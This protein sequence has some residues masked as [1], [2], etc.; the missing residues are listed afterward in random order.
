M[1]YEHKGY[2]L[3]P[4]IKPNIFFSSLS[5]KWPF[6]VDYNVLH[7][8]ESAIVVSFEAPYIFVFVFR[9]TIAFYLLIPVNYDFCIDCDTL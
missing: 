9:Y 8:A 3:W 1:L 4:P 7:Y 2:K 6:Q 5:S